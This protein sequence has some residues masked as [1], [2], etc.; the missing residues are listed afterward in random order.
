[1]RID[2]NADLGEG[3]TDDAGLLEVA[4]SANLA[5]GFH[6]G[7]EETMRAGVHHRREDRRG[8][9]GAGLLRRPRA[10]R[11]P[12]PRSRRADVLTGVG[13]GAGPAAHQDR[14]R[15]AAPRSPTSSRTERSTTGSS[16]TRSRPR[17]PARERLAAGAR[18][19]RFGDPP[20]RRAGRSHR[21]RGGLPRPRLH[22]GRQAGA[23]RPAGGTGR[24]RRRDRGQRGR[25]G[26]GGEVRSLCVH[27]DSPGAVDA[28]RAVR[29]AL[30]RGGV[31]RAPLGT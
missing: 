22:R 29:A 15:S 20:P 14:G 8:D 10:L 3:V 4:T 26:R 19:S 18:A 2:L 25:D 17:G 27:G 11:P 6:A 13:R 28:A 31:R 30:E 7:D 21:R 23:A 16:T 12:P 1:M 24:R 9:R 5:C